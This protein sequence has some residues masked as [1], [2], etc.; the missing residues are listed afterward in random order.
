MTTQH[1]DGRSLTASDLP[2]MSKLVEDHTELDRHRLWALR[3]VSMWAAAQ[4]K[5]NRPSDRDAIDTIAGFGNAWLGFLIGKA[6]EGR[7][8]FVQHDLV[9][10]FPAFYVRDKRTKDRLRPAP[11]SAWKNDWRNVLP[12]MGN[13]QRLTMLEMEIALAIFYWHANEPRLVWWLQEYPH[14]L[15]RVHAYL[16]HNYGFKLAGH[17]RRAMRNTKWAG[18]RLTRQPP[19]TAGFLARWQPRIAGL[20]AIGLLGILSVNHL[21]TLIF[22]APLGWVGV[23]GLVVLVLTFLLIL[24]DVFKQNRGVLVS[25]KHAR[26]RALGVLWRALAWGAA[27][28]VTV[29][30]ILRIILSHFVH[31]Q[32]LENWVAYQQLPDMALP[33]LAVQPWWHWVIRFGTMGVWAVLLGLLLQWFWE[34]RSVTEPI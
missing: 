24:M 1:P 2:T 26:L 4:K 7:S 28:T 16:L 34:D 18:R 17:L 23:G 30:A 11:R 22:A 12:W 15:W 20:T 31:R 8:F 10:T 14:I 33:H 6:A 13:P 21:L 19:F 5:E 27:G 32:S 29:F 9:R 3:N 25:F